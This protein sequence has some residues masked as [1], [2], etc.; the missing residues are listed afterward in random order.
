[1]PYVEQ[2]LSKMVKHTV[3]GWCTLLT[4]RT[5]TSGLSRK[6]GEGEFVQGQCDA[7]PMSGFDV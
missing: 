2:N 1:M 6:A 5:L 7:N 3:E 4:M